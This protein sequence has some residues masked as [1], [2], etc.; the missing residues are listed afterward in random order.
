MGYHPRYRAAADQGSRPVQRRRHGQEC[1][2]ALPRVI[3]SAS[4]FSRATLFV[5]TATCRETFTVRKISF[6]VGVERTS[7]CTPQDREDRGRASR[8]G[9]S[10]Q[11]V[12]PARQGGQGCQDRAK[13]HSKSLPNWCFGRG[14]LGPLFLFHFPCAAAFYACI[15]TAFAVG[16]ACAKCFVAWKK[17]RRPET[18]ETNGS[19]ACRNTRG[20]EGCESRGIRGACPRPCR[21][22]A[23]GGQG[24]P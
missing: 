20:T 10:C 16:F 23:Q 8:Q 22:R 2:I 17:N 24:C 11:A 6:G 14:P 3:A 13:R 5:V 9:P 1:T 18:R 7:P 12:L 19:N 15:S 4:R 21:R